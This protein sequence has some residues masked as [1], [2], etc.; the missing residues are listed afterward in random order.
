M[1]APSILTLLSNRGSGFSIPPHDYQAFT[2]I[3]AG[4]SND[5]NVAT[6]TF[7]LGGSGGSVVAKLTFT[8]VGSTNNV[9]TATLSPS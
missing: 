8:Y 7:R 2:Y 9:L 6:I 5:D 4:A 1:A 3:S